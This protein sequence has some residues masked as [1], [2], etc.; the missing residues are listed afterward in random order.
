M[1]A[2]LKFINHHFD[3]IFKF[4]NRQIFKLAYFHIVQILT[5][6]FFELA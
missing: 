4:S 2:I 5:K 3:I 6:G 1:K